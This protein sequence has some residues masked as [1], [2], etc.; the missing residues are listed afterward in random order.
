MEAFC[1]CIFLIL[2]LRMSNLKVMFFMR[3]CGSYRA[4]NDLRDKLWNSSF[5]LYL[6]CACSNDGV[7]MRDK[8]W[9]SSISNLDSG[10]QVNP[11]T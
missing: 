10:I 6:L 11:D 5:S 9:N 1:K 4:Y 3:K 8:L 2:S 7:D